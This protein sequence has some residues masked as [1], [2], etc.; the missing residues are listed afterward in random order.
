MLPSTLAALVLLVIAV[1][2]IRLF[3]GVPRPARP[4]RFVS[5]RELAFLDAAADTLLPAI[6]DGLAR[7]GATAELADFVDR[8]VGALPPRQRTLIRLML[9]FFE[10]STLFFPARGPG[11]FRRFSK[12]SVEQR[13]RVLEAWAS[14][15]WAVRR[16]FFTALRAFVVMG[17]L[18]HED[19]LRAL[20][21]A[22]W[23][24]ESPVIEADLLYPPIGEPSA[25]IR[26]TEDDLAG[27]R[28]TRPLRD[29]G[30]AS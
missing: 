24:V 7:P 12:L 16:S 1:V 22:P 2:C 3:V 30:G 23:A 25:S 10:Q 19:N 27:V 18:G 28:D 11:G 17:V 26:L 29:A 6:D 20:G 9:V 13:H 8:Y 21:L 5:N 15:R 4:S 14:S